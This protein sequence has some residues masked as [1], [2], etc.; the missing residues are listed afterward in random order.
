MMMTILEPSVQFLR[1]QRSHSDDSVSAVLQTRG[2]SVN[3]SPVSTF[4]H[5]FSAL[6]SDH[7]SHRQKKNLKS[8]GG[9]SVQGSRIR[10][11]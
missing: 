7:F 5:M 4:L 8:L 2:P 3:L 10:L 11:R 9:S 6:L 1:S